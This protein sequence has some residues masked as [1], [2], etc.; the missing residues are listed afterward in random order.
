MEWARVELLADDPAAAEL[1]AR[2]GYEELDRLGDRGYL[3]TIA[4]IL[5]RAVYL[6]G[7]HEE[8][9]QLTRV[10]EGAADP[11]DVSSQSGW[12]SVRA[13]A[14]AS[15]GLI[16]DAVT[17]ARSAVSIMERTD[18]LDSHAEA[19]LDLAEVLRLSG[20]ASEAATPAAE[21]LRLWEQKGNLVSAERAR[22]LLDEVTDL[23]SVRSSARAEQ[24]PP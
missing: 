11:D 19:L 6:Q 24:D 18:M 12:R 23:R 15:R 13:L 5:A 9:E 21:A 16:E 8:A 22:R 20:R 10:S 1:V 3:S 7:R 14:L 17:L 2:E 4:P